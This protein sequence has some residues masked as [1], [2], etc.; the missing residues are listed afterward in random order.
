[1][2]A[3]DISVLSLLALWVI[4]SIIYMKKRKNG[5]CCGDCSQCR[6]NCQE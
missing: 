5:A 1:M 3:L 2:N 4:G 6:K